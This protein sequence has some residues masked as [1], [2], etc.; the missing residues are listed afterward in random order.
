MACEVYPLGILPAHFLYSRNFDPN[1]ISRFWITSAVARNV[2]YAHWVRDV[3]HQIIQ[4]PQFMYTAVPDVLRMEPMGLPHQDVQMPPTLRQMP[5]GYVGLELPD[6]N[7]AK[8][9][10]SGALD[11]AG[12][13]VGGLGEGMTYLNGSVRL[14]NGAYNGSII[15]IR[16]YPTGWGGGS[17]ASIVTYD[18][19]PLGK[20]IGRGS[21]AVSAT[22]GATGIREAYVAERKSFGYRTQVEAARTANRKRARCCWH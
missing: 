5:A 10:W 7:E 11:L 13:A 15:S 1:S 18:A 9:V 22:I 16:Y 2:Y 20:W 6:A 3:G 12:Y 21:I 4:T 17:N 19:A 14:T 8:N